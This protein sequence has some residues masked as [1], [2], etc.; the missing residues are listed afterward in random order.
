MAALSLRYH[1]VLSLWGRSAGSPLGTTVYDAKRRTGTA[2]RESREKV[3]AVCLCRVATC[4]SLSAL[5]NIP[6]L[7]QQTSSSRLPTHRCFALSLRLGNGGYR[8]ESIAWTDMNL[9]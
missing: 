5:R 6:G 1:P 8:R 4:A 3:S 2:S 9:P 7:R